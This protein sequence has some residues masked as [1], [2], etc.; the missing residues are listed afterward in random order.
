MPSALPA[1]PPEPEH[2]RPP[3][4]APAVRPRSSPLCP[5][6]SLPDPAPTPPALW[7]LAAL[8]GDRR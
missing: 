7:T 8:R 6:D 1:P 3:V 5:A 2:T 4:R